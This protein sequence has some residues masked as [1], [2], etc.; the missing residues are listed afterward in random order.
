[1]DPEEEDSFVED[2]MAR[3]PTS[4]MV[5]FLQDRKQFCMVYTLSFFMFY[6]STCK[7]GLVVPHQLYVRSGIGSSLR[8]IE[9]A[10]TW[11]FENVFTS[12]ASYQHYVSLAPLF[13]LFCKIGERGSDKTKTARSPVFSRRFMEY[14]KK[15]VRWE[16]WSAAVQVFGHIVEYVSE[17]RA[18]RLCY[19]QLT[20]TTKK[21]KFIEA[22]D[23]VF[24]NDWR[25]FRDALK[26]YISGK[27]TRNGPVI[28]FLNHVPENEANGRH[29]RAIF[30]FMFLKAMLTG[31]IPGF[32]TRAKGFV[33][34][35]LVLT[36]TTPASP[37]CVTTMGNPNQ[38]VFQN[39]EEEHEARKEYERMAQGEEPT[40]APSHKGKRQ[41]EPTMLGPATF[42]SQTPPVGE[43]DV[44][45]PLPKKRGRPPKRR[46]ASIH[47]EK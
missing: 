13:A 15:Q 41:R 19:V 37:N 24:T 33:F 10:A 44:A 38:H 25:S 11:F 23:I 29:P 46:L 22:G 32:D 42:S 45:R 39:E 34:V 4:P 16:H 6:M 1:M 26:T 9:L 12:R 27:G 40:I 35:R 18:N 2:L 7:R 36:E 28:D 8:S 3:K 21:D 20:R 17:L 5:M 47:R 43:E 31:R 30:A 14:Y